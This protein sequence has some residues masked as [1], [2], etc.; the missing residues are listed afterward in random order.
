MLDPAV[1]ARLNALA[2]QARDMT[3]AGYFAKTDSRARRAYT[4][5]SEVIDNALAILE[6]EARRGRI[7]RVAQ[8]RLREPFVR[9]G[10]DLGINLAIIALRRDNEYAAQKWLARVLLLDPDNERA[11]EL[12]TYV[13]TEFRDRNRRRPGKPW[14]R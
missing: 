9:Q 4:D 14:L 12:R 7:T 13:V 8:A 5:A 10:A 6:T 3:Q 1:H 2:R 11:H